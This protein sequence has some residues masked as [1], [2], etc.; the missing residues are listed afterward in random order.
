MKHSLILF[1][2]K[3]TSSKEVSENT[4]KGRLGKGR[5]QIAV[6]HLLTFRAG[7]FS[8]GACL[9]LWLTEREEQTGVAIFL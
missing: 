4:A 3:E 2:R 1:L 5:L 7:F 6:Y 9:F 8:D